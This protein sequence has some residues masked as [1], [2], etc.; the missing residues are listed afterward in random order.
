MLVAALSFTVATAYERIPQVSVQSYVHRPRS[1]RGLLQG[2][3]EATI[4]IPKQCIQTGLDLQSSCAAEIQRA[5]TFF[6]ISGTATSILAS[7]AVNTHRDKIDQYLADSASNPSPE[8]CR[9]SAAFNAGKCSCDPNVVDLFKSFTNNDIGTYEKVATALG[10]SCKFD[11]LF[12]PTC[13]I[14]VASSS[15]ERST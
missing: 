10:T 2:S 8:C 14:S 13:S 9:A 15:I 7:T 6:G 4:T 11:V 5:S 1:E 3:Q 12:G